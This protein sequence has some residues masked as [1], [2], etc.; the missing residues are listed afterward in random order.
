MSRIS[1]IMFTRA[2]LELFWKRFF[3]PATTTAPPVSWVHVH[4]PDPPMG[5]FTSAPVYRVYPLLCIF[6]FFY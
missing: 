1:I 6:S 2:I 3:D 4:D 5:T